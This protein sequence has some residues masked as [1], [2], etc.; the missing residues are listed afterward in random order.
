MV[1]RLIANRWSAHGQSRPAHRPV[2]LLGGNVNPTP[3]E[4]PSQFMLVAAMNPTPDGV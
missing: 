2:G 3:W 4:F 1:R